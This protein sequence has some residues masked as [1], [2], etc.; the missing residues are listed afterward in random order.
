MFFLFFLKK[1]TQELAAV[2][3]DLQQQKRTHQ[4]HKGRS[5]A[6]HAR[7]IAEKDD[8]LVSMGAQ[9]EDLKKALRQTR[10]VKFLQV[11]SWTESRNY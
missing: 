3:R 1:K 6:E 10:R 8:A 7:I 2:T 11:W 4:R 5:D 9:L